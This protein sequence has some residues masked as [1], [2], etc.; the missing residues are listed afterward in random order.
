MK[1]NI[2]PKNDNNN[3]WLEILKDLPPANTAHGEIAVDFA[4]IGAGFTGLAA[5]RRLAG[6]KP[7][8]RIALIDAGRIGNNA[9][10]RSS[11]FIIDQAHN[12]RA[13]DFAASLD[14]E[15]AQITLNNA[16]QNFLRK[17]VTENRISC[18][19]D[20]GGKTHSAGTEKGAARLNAYS[21]NLDL[22]GAS[23]SWLDQDQMRAK[24]GSTFYI[25]GLHTLGTILV[26]PAA[27]VVG[28][29]QS[30][31]DNVD[32]Y[33]NTPVQSINYGAPHKISMPNGKITAKTILLTNNGFASQFG[34]YKS[35]LIPVTTWASLTRRLTNQELHD[36][37]GSGSWGIIPADAFGTSVRKVVG[38]RILIRNIYNYSQG[39]NPTESDRQWA[40]TLHQRSFRNRFAQLPDVE[41][42]YT[43]GG[44]LSLSRNGEPVF[45]EL[46]PGVFGAFCLNGVGIARGTIYGASLSELVVGAE[47]EALSIMSNAGRPN[48]LPPKPFLGWGVKIN[49]AK[50]RHDAGMEL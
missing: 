14:S 11:G 25:K 24:T 18:N 5:A 48:N 26:Q 12:I 7:D 39:L 44:A 2:L 9:A 43:W 23:Y 40:K 27:L 16:G 35:H 49:F 6:L 31:P 22:L 32:V 15:K 47:S 1:I 38:D 17:A 34:F 20:E 4:I 19:W 3:G 30:L 33:E 8:S 29:G 46:A 10:G 45:G 28:L 42:E 50:R 36:L 21:K 13:T 41:F 37:G